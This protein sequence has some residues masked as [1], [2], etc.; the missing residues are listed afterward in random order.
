MKLGLK[1]SIALTG[2]IKKGLIKKEKRVY[3][4]FIGV[5][6]RWTRNFELVLCPSFTFIANVKNILPNTG[7]TLGAQD[8][9]WE[10]KGSYTGEI[11][12][13]QIEE[14]G[15]KYVIIGHSE[16][17]KFLKETDEM[18]HKKLKLA[19]NTGLIPV[20]CIGE[21][22]EDRQ[23]GQKDD[24]IVFQLMKALEGIKVKK[25]QKLIIGYEPVWAIGTGQAVDPKE[26]ELSANLIKKSLLNFFS[27]DFVDSNVTIIY[28]ASVSG[29]DTKEF[30]S[31]PNIGGLLVGTASLDADEFLKIINRC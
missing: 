24:V 30:L 23:S 10:E 25:W 5:Q 3:D 7:I 6:T 1:E 28:G 13:S 11:C 14:L 20:L 29:K 16:R 18:I 17:R 26:A 21:T 27:Q 15:V 19:F 2:K 4:K 22:F 8:M 12:A 31:Q 9:F